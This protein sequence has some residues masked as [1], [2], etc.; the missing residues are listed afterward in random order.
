MNAPARIVDTPERLRL[1]VDDF[2][3]L[4]D[5]GAFADYSKTELIEGDIYGMNAQHSRHARVQSRLLVALA[6][7]LREM[8]SDLEAW[9]EV[10]IRASETSAP[11]PDIVLTRFRGDGEIP[12]DMVALV[13]EIADTTLETDLGRKAELYAAAGVPEYW[14][15][16]VNGGRVV[17]Y[18]QPGRDGY[19]RRA[20][21]ALGEA[22]VA[23][24]IAGL[25]VGTAELVG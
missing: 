21:M 11:E 9:V 14:V 16:D 7:R 23:T 22:L 15:V 4:N 25:E 8:G 19:A 2:L 18:D 10:T 6:M 12:A 5:S 24:T 1:R 20:E 3:L 17:Q 13:V